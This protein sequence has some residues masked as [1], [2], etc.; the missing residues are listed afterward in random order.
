M[1]TMC[2]E[3]TSDALRSV[4]DPESRCVL[5]PNGVATRYI[6][7]PEDILSE[8]EASGFQLLASKVRP[9]R[10]VESD[11]DELQVWATPA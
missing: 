4:L 3:V 10:D 5:D 2:G 11:M 1:A 7:L 9:R 8:I 6:G